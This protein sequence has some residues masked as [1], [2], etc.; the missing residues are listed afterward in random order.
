MLYLLTCYVF[1]SFVSFCPLPFITLFNPSRRG[2]T[3]LS[4]TFATFAASYCTVQIVLS[5][6]LF[7][8]PFLFF[9][10]LHFE[11]RGS[12]KRRRTP[13]DDANAHI[14]AAPSVLGAPVASVL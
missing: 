7:V 3:M 4:S 8:F 5:L 11:T 13:R 1:I 10:N 9:Y 2:C 6:F 14:A 12:P